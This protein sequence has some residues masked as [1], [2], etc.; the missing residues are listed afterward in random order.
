[1][2][3]HDWNE[4]YRSGDAPWD[5]G[6]PNAHLLEFVRSYPLVKG[7]ALDIGCGSGTNVLWL[8]GQGFITLGVDVSS[9]AIQKARSKAADATRYC[10]LVVADFL[11]DPIAGAPFDF[12]FDLGCFHLFDEFE[13][14]ARFVERV[15]SL[16]DG[17]NGGKWLSIIGS[18]EGPARDF[19]P[20]RRS[21]RDVISVIEPVLEIL[22]FRAITFQAN[23]PFPVAGWLCAS[24]LR[25]DSVSFPMPR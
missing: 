7:R 10:D 6:E 24:R 17:A 5:T 23:L 11:S 3:S 22:E 8:A 2:P 14:Q 4:R 20:P 25:Q 19:G 12:I 16:L 18:T 9:V 21:A 15:A 13:E 1:M